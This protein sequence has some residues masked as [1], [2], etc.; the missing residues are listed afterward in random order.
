MDIRLKKQQANIYCAYKDLNDLAHA[1]LI[2]LICPS[3]PLAGYVPAL[4]VL[5]FSWTCQVFLELEPLFIW[6]PLPLPGVLPASSPPVAPPQRGLPQP[7]ILKYIPFG[8]FLSQKPLPFVSV[9]LRPLLE[10][11]HPVGRDSLIQC[12]YSSSELRAGFTEMYHRYFWVSQSKLNKIWCERA[13]SLVLSGRKFEN[14]NYCQLLQK[15]L[16]A[17]IF[18]IARPIFRILKNYIF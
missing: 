4:P 7:P 17:S 1:C 11:K 15:L 13:H 9:C 12:C 8:V 18:L 3:L 5:M 6:F 10:W 2:I 16:S 14:S